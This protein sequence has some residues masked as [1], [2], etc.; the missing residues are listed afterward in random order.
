MARLHHMPM[1]ELPSGQPRTI[2]RHATDG[3]TLVAL[4]TRMDLAV[5]LDLSHT[6][7]AGVLNLRGKPVHKQPREC[8]RRHHAAQLERRQHENALGS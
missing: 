5:L 4:A 2:K 3:Q 7:A 1:L 6:W 8:G